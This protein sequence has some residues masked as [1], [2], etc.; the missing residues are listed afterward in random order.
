MEPLIQ[1][2]AAKIPYIG[3]LAIHYWYV[4]IRAD[5][6]TRWEVWQKPHLA[7]ESWGYLHKNLM[8]ATFGVGNG[9]SW[10]ETVWVGESAQQLASII[11]QSP[12]TY[13][14]CDRYCYF[15]GPNSNTYAQWV[16]KQ[17]HIPYSLHIKGIGKHYC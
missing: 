15:P 1:L 14:F 16:L 5:Q 11:E 8:P 13:P 12:Q 17:A 3:W 4:V 6:V 7:K 9:A 10:I 2:R